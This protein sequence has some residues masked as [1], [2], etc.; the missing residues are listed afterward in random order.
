VCWCLT[1]FRWVFFREFLALLQHFL[2]FNRENCKDFTVNS[3][4]SLIY[5]RNFAHLTIFKPKHEHTRT[6]YGILLFSCFFSSVPAMES[7]SGQFLSLFRWHKRFSSYLSSDLVSALTSLNMN[8]FTHFGLECF[9]IDA[10]NIKLYIK[11][12]LQRLLILKFDF[13]TL[14]KGFKLGLALNSS[15]GNVHFRRENFVK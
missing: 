11:V 15:A 1:A 3:M 7:L 2:D 6:F 4:I 14:C 13:K 9:K 8:D 10:K 5:G 12:A